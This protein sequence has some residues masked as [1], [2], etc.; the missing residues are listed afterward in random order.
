[1]TRLAHFLP[2]TKAITGKETAD[3]YLKE[4]FRLHGLP[5]VIVSDRDVRFMNRFW[6]TLWRRLGTK[7]NMSSGQHPETDGLSERV[8]RTTQE[9]CRA[10][11]AYDGSN[12]AEWLPYV[13][14]SYNATVTLGIEHSPFE[15]TYGFTPEVPADTLFPMRPTIPISL[16][17]QDRIKDIR[18]IHEAVRS[19][20]T[21]HKDEMTVPPQ[22]R[23]VGEAPKLRVGDKAMII[24]KRLFLRGQANTKLKDRHIG[25]FEIIEKIGEHSYRL[26]LPPAVRLHPVFH[27]NNLRPC[28]TAP[29][30]PTQPIVTGSGDDDDEFQVER[31]TAVKIGT[32]PGRRGKY[33]MFLTYFADATIAPIWHILNDVKRTEALQLFME[34]PEYTTFAESEEYVKF[35]HEFPTRIPTA[36]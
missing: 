31:I 36:N 29:L 12:W 14:F 25:P 10:F 15:A 30:R 11:C 24:T 19:I 9:L 6:Q 8:N 18:A 35:M 34:T 3:L 13:E 7:L 17:A 26:K 1:M 21:L 22:T 28:E 16:D 27:I 32:P 23:K 20:L 2:C 4:I 33:L 5:R